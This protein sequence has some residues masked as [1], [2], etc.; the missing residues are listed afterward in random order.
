MKKLLR[1]L[2][3]FHARVRPGMKD[4]F[5]RLAHRQQP[6]VLLVAC[7]DSR[8]APNVFA[9]TDPGEVFVVRNVGNLVPPADLAGSTGAAVEFAVMTLKVHDIVVCGHS[10]C[11]A[12]EQVRAGIERASAPHLGRWLR[13]ARPVV[14]GGMEPDEHS[15]ANVLAQ[16][17]NLRT[18]P[19]VAEAE[20]A[21]RLRLHGWWFEIKEA[22]VH[23]WD[24]AARRWAVLD[25]ARVEEE[26]RR[27]EEPGAQGG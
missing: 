15:R 20:G 9:S 19:C 21:G 18:Y 23:L 24:E 4:L 16:V 13:H 7:S 3:D 11:G 1:G 8:V 25:A 10:G 27:L 14:G 5:A 26:I 17:G 22:Q 6:D 2:A 12:I